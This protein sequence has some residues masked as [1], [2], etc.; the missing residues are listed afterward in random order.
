M[1]N[2]SKIMRF[3]FTDFSRNKGISVA[4][5]FIL[6]VTVMLATFIFF[7]QGSANYL[8]NQIQDKIDI[9]AY[10][11]EGTQDADIII[12]QDEIKKLPI[13]KNVQYISADQALENFKEK[14]GKN[15]TFNKA[16]A[17]VGDNPLLS[18]LNIITNG[19]PE[20]YQQISDILQKPEYSDIV[21]SVDLSQK[22]DVINKVYFIKYSINKVGLILGIILVIIATLVVFN[23]IKLTVDSLKEEI[24]TMKIVG[25]S[26]WFIRGPF[27][28]QGA[29]YGLFA[30]IICFV[31]TGVCAYLL[32]SQVNMILPGF[33]CFE[34][35]VV[36]ILWFMLIQLGFGTGV[37]VI[38]SYLAVR[39]Y[40][41]V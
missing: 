10:F 1:A 6:T 12:I 38:S 27:I 24:A 19:N 33:D 31:I 41:K 5:I 21:N 15:D 3:A 14:Y 39:R 11:K 4:A 16:L 28:V 37:S 35:F 34:Y 26:D 29:I 9:T 36:N 13:V 23:T 7:F 8:I 40:L 20:Q 25:A 30:F 18:S 2:F 17:E 22:K 32:R